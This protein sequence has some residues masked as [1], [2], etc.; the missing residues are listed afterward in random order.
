MN[1]YFASAIRGAGIGS[2]RRNKGNRKPFWEYGEPSHTPPHRK[3]KRLP[4]GCRLP[5]GHSG[6]LTEA[7]AV[8]ELA[9]N[10]MR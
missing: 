6:W 4:E 5:V 2:N 7:E 10:R 3:G 1:Q 8:C 9:I